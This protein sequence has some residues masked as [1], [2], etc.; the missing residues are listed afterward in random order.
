MNMH[1]S[2]YLKTIRRQIC[3]NV[4]SAEEQRVRGK[5]S[6]PSCCAAPYVV[7]IAKPDTV[8]LCIK[9]FLSSPYY[10]WVIMNNISVQP[11][12]SSFLFLHR[13]NVSWATF[14]TLIN[15][16]DITLDQDQPSP[17]EI[18]FCLLWKYVSSWK[19]RFDIKVKTLHLETVDVKTS[20]FLC[21]LLRS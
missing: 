19:I 8:E 1:K 16:E 13:A 2:A 6:H 20:N 15:Q 12:S 11:K 14:P 9:F 5:S 21:C 17:K 10:Y 7:S 18:A 4:G 3:C